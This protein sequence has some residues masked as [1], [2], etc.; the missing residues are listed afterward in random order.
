MIADVFIAGEACQPLKKM[1]PE[2]GYSN[3]W[4]CLL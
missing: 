2:T 4:W 1:L 3:S